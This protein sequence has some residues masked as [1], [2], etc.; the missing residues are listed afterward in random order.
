MQLDHISATFPSRPTHTLADRL[1]SC[2]LGRRHRCWLRTGELARR[3]ELIS[4]SRHRFYCHCQSRGFTTTD[5]PDL[6]LSTT[7]MPPASPTAV[8]TTAFA[9]SAAGHPRL[10]RSLR[11]ME[12]SGADTSTELQP[13]DPLS[14]THF[15]PRA[16][17]VGT[18][19]PQHAGGFLKR[20][21]LGTV[22]LGDRV[23][24]G[25]WSI[26]LGASRR[27]A[28]G[29]GCRLT[30]PPTTTERSCFDRISQR[31]IYHVTI[32]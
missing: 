30:W 6:R 7:R 15:L 16:K 4:V 28:H 18:L 24:T 13:P 17:S 12:R 19:F 3:G 20:P 8:P 25:A 31:L 14:P 27:A 23:L 10:E 1:F 2:I 29:Y 11:H 21:A 26:E 22:S 5:S 32:E 9:S